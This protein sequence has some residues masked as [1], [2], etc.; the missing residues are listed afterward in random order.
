MVELLPPDIR[1]YE[2]I[3]IWSI[4]LPTRHNH[5]LLETIPTLNHRFTCPRNRLRQEI[6][7][8]ADIKEA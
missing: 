7:T 5:R 1:V 6:E 3:C 4:N 2:N 8:R